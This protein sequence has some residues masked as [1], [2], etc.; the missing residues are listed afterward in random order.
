M[1]RYSVG[2]GVLLLIV[3]SLAADSYTAIVDGLP[4]GRFRMIERSGRPVVLEELRGKVWIVHFFY[5][6]CQ[7]PCTKTVPTMRRLQ[8]AFLGK[9]DILL[10]S[11]AL[12]GDDPELL[13]RF[14]KDFEADVDQW[15]FLTTPGDADATLDIVQK[16]FF[17]TAMRKSG[18]GPGDEFDHTTNLIVV[19]REGLIRGY[20]DGRDPDAVSELIPRVRALAAQRYRQPAIN[21]TLN[22]LSAACLVLGWWAIKRRRERL[23]MACMLLALAASAVFLASYLWFHFVVLEGRP[24]SFRGEGWVRGLYFAILISHTVLAIVAAPLALYTSYQG[25]RDRR[26]RHVRVARWTL[27]LWLYV[28]VTGVAVYV[29]LYLLYPPY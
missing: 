26:P 12:A 1:F 28:S 18:G 4:V 20:V 16:C 22:G 21:A 5:P 9:P 23:H 25:L 29:M 8:Q 2:V 10:V 13:R 27:P 17:Q 19:D 14:A 7:G 15:L 11:I 3:P 24:T 6:S